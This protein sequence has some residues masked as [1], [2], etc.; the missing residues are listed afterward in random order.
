MTATVEP[1]RAAT[2]PGCVADSRPPLLRV[3]QVA[4]G[5]GARAGGIASTEMSR[6]SEADEFGSSHRGFR[7]VDDADLTTQA[8]GNEAVVSRRRS[9][10]PWLRLRRR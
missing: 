5:H 3:T 2:K 9:R 6:G 10:T 8:S 4:P 1:L 7:R